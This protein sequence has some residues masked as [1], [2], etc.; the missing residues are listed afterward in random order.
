[1]EAFYKR[2]TDQP[3]NIEDYDHAKNVWQEFDIKT[4]GKYHD[5][6]LKTDVLLLAD[7]FESLEKCVPATTN[8]I[9]PITTRHRTWLGMPC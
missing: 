2:L 1:M 6:Y 3:I 9:R 8:S 7:V 5:L 4:L